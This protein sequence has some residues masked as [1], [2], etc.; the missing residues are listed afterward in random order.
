MKVTVYVPDD[1][2][3][4]AAFSGG[5]LKAMVDKNYRRCGF[6]FRDG[7]TASAHRTAAGNYVIWI[8]SPE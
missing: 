2:P 5:V 4:I 3:L 1:K 6:T 7:S 8:E